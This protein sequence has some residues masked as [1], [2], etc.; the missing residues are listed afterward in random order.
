[1]IPSQTSEI[2]YHFSLVLEV[3]CWT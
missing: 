3:L 2:K 1:L